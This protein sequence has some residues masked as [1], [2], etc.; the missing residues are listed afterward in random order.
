VFQSVPSLLPSFLS[1]SLCFVPSYLHST[2]HFFIFSFTHSV[3]SPSS[4]IY[5]FSFFPSFHPSNF[6]PPRLLIYSFHNMRNFDFIHS[7][8]VCLF[9]FFFLCL[10]DFLS[11]WLSV[12]FF[13]SIFLLP[14]FLPICLPPPPTITSLLS[15][16]LVRIL[17]SNSQTSTT[18]PLQQS[19]V[20]CLTPLKSHRTL[21][22][23]LTSALVV[24]HI[25]P[26]VPHGSTY[27][28]YYRPA[29][30]FIS[31]YRRETNE[32]ED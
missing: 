21:S 22:T 9:L 14:A 12:C 32:E 1:V 10:F 29:R 4:L 20:L 15:T 8:Y 18:R 6:P 2:L 27:T 25:R 5:L 13:L 3:L 23:V 19:C 31:T 24:R 11:V 26:Y 7:L 16:L 17:L 28:V 30:L